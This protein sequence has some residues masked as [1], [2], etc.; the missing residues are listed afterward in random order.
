M[1]LCREF[2]ETLWKLC[3]IVFQICNHVFQ[4]EQIK[5]ESCIQNGKIEF[6]LEQGVCTA[7]GLTQDY[8]NNEWNDA[9]NCETC[10]AWLI[11]PIS[12]SQIIYAFAFCEC[13]QTE[14]SM[15]SPSASHILSVIILDLA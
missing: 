3:S 7:I 10:M 14:L 15:H 1:I 9:R 4:L 2:C 6:P 11:D 5:F 8:E 12:D 13:G